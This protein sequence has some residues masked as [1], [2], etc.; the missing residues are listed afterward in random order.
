MST[1]DPDPTLP[2][3]SLPLD[4]PQ[5]SAPPPENQK[6]DPY[7]AL[8]NPDYR[9]YFIGNACATF[10]IQMAGVTVAWELYAKTNSAF[11][12]GLVGMVQIVPIV[13]FA[14]IAGHIVDRLNRQRLILLC[15]FCLILSY[16]ALGLSSRYASALPNT[17]ILGFA[18]TLLSRFASLVGGGDQSAAHFSN[19]HIPIMLALLFFNGCV[20][21]L[22]QPA[23]YAIVPMLVSTDELPNAATWTSSMFETCN[24]LGPALAGGVMAILLGNSFESHWAYASIYWFTAFCQL[25]QFIN[26]ARIHM[27]HPER[28]REPTTL[29]T[30]LAGVRFVYHNKII[31]STITLDL[32]AVLLGGA[33]A[34][35]PLFAKDILHVGPLGLGI[36]RAAPSVG[37]ITMSLIVAHTPPME[38]AGRN[39][40]V[41]VAG[42]G[43]ATIVFGLSRNFALSLVALAL[44]GAFDA[45]SVIVRHSLVQIL[46][47][48]EMRGR[49]SAVNSVFI[50]TS[51]ELGEFESG[52]TAQWG[53]NLLGP[54]YGPMAAV[55][56]GGLGTILVVAT[57]SLA[58]PQVRKV[59][60]LANPHAT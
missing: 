7:A 6:H 55:A 35:L 23:K 2:Y 52:L 29:K 41:A 60:Q 54:L 27:H 44:T 8:R 10:G 34:L 13:G 51:N 58:W 28:K 42:F 25:V 15:T 21:S 53:K 5:P 31:L 14:L 26:V 40:L 56:A 37:A 16:F 24:M 9:R 1:P 20:R 47:P 17:G 19:P 4:Q 32:F 43:A 57:V 48:D 50:S 39:M 33:V 22:N 11:A 36:L 3:Q 18:N 49:V 59:K 46:T 45:I 12:L 38:N 30:I